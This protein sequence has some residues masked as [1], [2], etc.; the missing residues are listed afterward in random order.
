MNN[1]KNIF[2][3]TLLI[4]GVVL[5]WFLQK[6]AKERYASHESPPAPVVEISQPRYQ[7]PDFTLNDLDGGTFRLADVRGD[8]VALIFWTTW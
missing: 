8:V 3:I 7:A 4:S 1:S 5:L 6:N 2:L